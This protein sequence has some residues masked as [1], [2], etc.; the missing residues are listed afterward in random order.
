MD[1]KKTERL[2]PPNL[3]DRHSYIRA[4]SEDLFKLYEA[5]GRSI[6]LRLDMENVSMNLSLA[7]PCGL[8]VNELLSNAPSTAIRPTGRR[9]GVARP[10]P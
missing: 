8:I 2:F 9:R 3:A 1:R 4:L 10:D 6:R 7:M 5:T